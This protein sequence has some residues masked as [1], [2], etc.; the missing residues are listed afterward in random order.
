[1]QVVLQTRRRMV[2]GSGPLCL[3]EGSGTTTVELTAAA[4]AE[5]TSPSRASHRLMHQRLSPG[6]EHRKEA[7]V[8]TE[9]LRIRRDRP[10]RLR[11]GSKQ[12]AV[13]DP[14]VLGGDSGDLGR[15]REDDVKVL[16]VEQFGVACLDPR[17]AHQ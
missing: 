7:D 6:M 4:W 17:C 3:P 11:G 12:E 16:G 2:Y 5:V 1:M 9:V 8:H 10:Q 15:H 14:L 13:D